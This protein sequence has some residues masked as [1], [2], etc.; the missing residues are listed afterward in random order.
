MIDLE[1]APA[2]TTSARVGAGA[3]VE[4]TPRRDTER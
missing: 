4:A 1:A 2:T 3:M